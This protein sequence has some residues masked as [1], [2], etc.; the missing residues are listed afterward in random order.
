MQVSCP[1]CKE[2]IDVADERLATGVAKVRCAQCSFGFTIRLGDPGAGAPREEKDPATPLKLEGVKSS[3]D[4]TEAA[5]EIGEAPQKFISS[6]TRTLV[7]VDTRFEQQAEEVGA[8]IEEYTKE[9]KK[10]QQ[11]ITQDITPEVDPAAKAT[12]L[13]YPAP[14]LK[15]AKK[16]EIQPALVDEPTQQELLP[17]AE[18]QDAS[19]E[20]KNRDALSSRPTEP[21][22]EAASTLKPEPAIEPEIAELD[23]EPDV[24]VAPPPTPHEEAA[25]AP[26]PTRPPAPPA[27]P[28]EEPAPAQPD[29]EP[30]PAQ[31]DEEPAPAQPDEEPAPAQP[32]PQHRGIPTGIPA[33]PYAMIEIDEDALSPEDYDLSRPGQGKG[34]R[35]LGLLITIVL[36][37]TTL[38]FFFILIRNDWSLDMAHFDTMVNKAFGV[39]TGEQTKHELRGLLVSVPTLEKGKL[40]SGDPV[41]VARGTVKNNDTRS[42]RF[43]Y[44]KVT[45]SHHSR[46]VVSGTAPAANIFTVEELARMTRAEMQGRIIPK[47]KNGGNARI[48]G[49]KS[50]DFM[51]VLTKVPPDFSPADYTAAAEVTEAEVPLD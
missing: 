15:P 8:E 30:A 25:S 39:D 28:D 10:E 40:S 20:Q 16:Q 19:G 34:M 31:P 37:L 9:E 3:G 38:L 46:P 18:A 49:G 35:T 36:G 45:V 29:E 22:S 11:P 17:E 2:V 41:I 50:V 42:R 44:V 43:I 26:T 21:D 51:V 32:A 7:R 14:N 47:G 23:I 6:E 4:L 1:N 12:L 33:A 27:T 24:E 13:D 48:E 5:G